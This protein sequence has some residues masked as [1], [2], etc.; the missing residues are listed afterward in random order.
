MF[1]LLPAA[2]AALLMALAA[3]S[4]TAL[5]QSAC[6][7][8]ADLDAALETATV[9]FN[10]AG[11]RKS[12]NKTSRATSTLQAYSILLWEERSSGAIS[13]EEDAKWAL[14]VCLEKDDVCG[15]KK[16]K[17]LSKDLFK[18]VGKG[19]GSGRMNTK[20]YPEE[21]VSWAEQQLNCTTGPVASPDEQAFAGNLPPLDGLT[22][23][24]RFAEA[25]RRLN[26]D[27]AYD[28]YPQFTQ[29]CFETST[30]ACDFM[31]SVHEENDIEASKATAL[32][33][34]EKSCGMGSPFGCRF[35][36]IYYLQGRPGVAKDKLLAGARA[37]KACDLGDKLSCGVAANHWDD[38]DTDRYDQAK[39]RKYRELD[40]DRQSNA[41]SCLVYGYMAVNA[42][43]GPEDK[44]AARAAFTKACDGNDGLAC[45]F[46]GSMQKRGQG[47]PVDTAGGRAATQKA[48]DLGQSTACDALNR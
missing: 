26:A 18:A 38:P 16:L 22:G 14:A 40:C 35:A 29:A 8:G 12:N 4:G 7:A 13:T 2:L 25:L 17:D 9:D 32:K 47:G 48:C 11:G 39:S 43:G 23:Q 21:M 6:P 10:T 20:V 42:Q 46:L 45:M 33:F 41:G 31:A 30:E 27:K 5:A 15:G 28:A 37:T 1:R 3:V 44:A 34:G 24:A 36:S 19:H